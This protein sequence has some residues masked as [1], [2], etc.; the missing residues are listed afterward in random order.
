MPGKLFLGN[1]DP[2][3][4]FSTIPAIGTAL[5]GMFTG[6]FMMSDYLANKPLKKVLYL[7]LAAI[8]LMIIGRLWNIVFPINK[9]LWTSS[10]VLFAGGWSLLLLSVFYLVIDVWGFRKWAFPFVVIGLNSI[11][12]YMLNSGIINFEQMGEYFFGGLAGLF[13]EPARQVIIISGAILCMWTFLYIL[14]RNKIFLKV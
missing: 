12:I 9:N 13:S 7:V 10:F 6:E 14:Y 2:E 11:L 1:H 5:L 4:L 8:G 3:G